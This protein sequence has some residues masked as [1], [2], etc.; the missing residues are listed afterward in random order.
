MEVGHRGVPD[1]GGDRG[2]AGQGVIQRPALRFEP[3]ALALADAHMTGGIALAV[4]IDQQRPRPGP[5]QNIDHID[6]GLGLGHPALL[7]GHG[8]DQTPSV[9][10]ERQFPE[11]DH[12]DHV[13]RNP[14]GPGFPARHPGPIIFATGHVIQPGC[15]VFLGHAP[16]LPRR[17][18]RISVHWPP[19]PARRFP[20]RRALCPRGIVVWANL[21]RLAQDVCSGCC[22]D[23]PE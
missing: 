18:H 9:R 19:L 15:K 4:G 21:M 16:P 22:D 2:F 13:S 11:H 17:L 6:A 14:L 5:G 10:T 12:A 7:V 3:F 23:I 8:D 20:P 1:H